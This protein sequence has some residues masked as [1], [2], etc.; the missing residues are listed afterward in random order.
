[1]RIGVT[2]LVVTAAAA[3]RAQS[4]AFEVASV[5]PNHTGD[6]PRTYPR[7]QN[8]TFRAEI[9]SLKTLIVVAYGLIELR[10]SGP[11]WLN[12]EKYDILAK[13]PES[14]PD[15]QLQP[16]LQ[17][18]LKDRFHLEAHFE[19]KEMPVYEMVIGK[20]GT[21]LKPF[22]PAQRLEIPQ[23]L[24]Q[25][26]LAMGVGTT[27]QIADALARAA[28]RPVLDKTGMAQEVR[29]EWMLNYAPLSTNGDAANSVAPDLFAAVEQQLG[30]KLESKRAS[31]RILVI[32]HADR[33]PTEN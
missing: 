7:L 13:A 15:T 12:T 27:S 16:L 24:G 28:G 11:D 17:A 6:H 22:D 33:V 30:L 29:Y 31:I 20:G 18:L 32:D 26:V 23:R 21:K 10:I 25:S 8:G 14:T 9:A 2:I 3:L 19:M 4:P 5:K 1:M